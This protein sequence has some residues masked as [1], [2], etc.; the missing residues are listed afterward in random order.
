MAKQKLQI[1]DLQIE[2][3]LIVYAGLRHPINGIYYVRGF[4]DDMVVIRHWNKDKWFYEFL[5]DEY[6]EAL[7]NNIK[8]KKK[9]KRWKN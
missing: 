9:E 1:K 3:K 4:V 6:L 7:Q 2:D 5:N 8:I